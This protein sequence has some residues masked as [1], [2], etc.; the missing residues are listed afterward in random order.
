MIVLQQSFTSV[1][2]AVHSRAAGPAPPHGVLRGSLNEASV[3]GW[4]QRQGCRTASWRETR[5]CP[6]SDTA[7]SG[8][9]HNG[10]T[11]YLRKG[12]IPKKSKTHQMER[13]EGKKERE[14][15]AWTLRWEEG[16]RRWSRC[17]PAA[18]GGDHYGADSRAVAYGGPHTG[19]GRCSLKELPPTESPHWS[20]L[21]AWGRR[22]RR[23]E[24]LPQPHC[25]RTTQGLGRKTP[26]DTE[27]ERERRKLLVLT[28]VFIFHYPNLF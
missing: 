26:S 28:F 14:T 17:F 21:K 15:R 6:A 22:C 20:R 25:P 5:S 9:L 23:E 16:R 1:N 19:A 4:R 3:A 10:S 13:G 7:S 27:S 11:A 2:P 8:Q 24:Q 12:R 18:H